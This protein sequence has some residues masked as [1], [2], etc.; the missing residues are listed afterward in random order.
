[1]FNAIRP[2]LFGKVLRA[3]EYPDGELRTLKIHRMNRQ[4]LQSLIAELQPPPFPTAYVQPEDI[5]QISVFTS[6]HFTEPV[7]TDRDV[8]AIPDNSWLLWSK[9]S[10]EDDPIPTKGVKLDGSHVKKQSSS[11]QKPVATLSDV[12][13]QDRA[14][15]AARRIVAS[16][17][18]GADNSGREDERTTRARLSQWQHDRVVDLVVDRDA[19]LLTVARNF[20]DDDDEFSRHIIRLLERRNPQAILL[21][22]GGLAG[23]GELSDVSEE[24]ESSTRRVAEPQVELAGRD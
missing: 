1:V 21:A 23:E 22:D 15:A 18:R 9:E 10:F 13:L 16:S 20:G 3:I 8:S 12:I 2:S 14:I 19:G 5:K 6:P 17:R 24:S 7:V 11:S 4:R